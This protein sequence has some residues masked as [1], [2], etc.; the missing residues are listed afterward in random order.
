MTP[1][2]ILGAWL[3]VAAGLVLAST[4]VLVVGGLAITK[5]HRVDTRRHGRKAPRSTD[6]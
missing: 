2:Q 6:G 1:H 3:L 5:D 4:V